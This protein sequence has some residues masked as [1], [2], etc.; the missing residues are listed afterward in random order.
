MTG[1]CPSSVSF[2][3]EN[4]GNACLTVECEQAVLELKSSIDTFVDPCKDFYGFSCGQ[5]GRANGHVSYMEA[6]HIAYVD[7]VNAALWDTGGLGA[8]APDSS[9]L[10]LSVV[11]RSCIKFF[12]RAAADIVEIWSASGIDAHVWTAVASFDSLFTLAVGNVLQY[13][14]ESVVDV[15]W[16]DDDNVSSLAGAYIA[17]GTAIARHLEPHSRKLL[18][19]RAILTLGDIVTRDRVPHIEHIDE[20]VAQRT[21]QLRSASET[22]VVA[23]RDL[24]TPKTN[25]SRVLADY[26]NMAGRSEPSSAIVQD[27]AG[28]RGVLEELANADLRAV[29]VYLTLVPLAKF[30]VFESEGQRRVVSG[31]DDQERR[32]KREACVR[33]LELLFGD[34]YGSWLSATVLRPGVADDVAQIVKDVV[35]VAK[36]TNKVFWR[37]PLKHE[38]VVAP[39]CFRSMIRRSEGGLPEPP[40]QDA[41]VPPKLRTDFVSNT[42]LFS[43]QRSRNGETCEP[44]ISLAATAMRWDDA[45]APLRLLVPDFYHAGSTEA[46]VNYGTLAYH[47]AAISFR[48]ALSKNWTSSSDYAPCIA[49]YVLTRLRMF[50]PGLSWDHVIGRHWALQVALWAAA[51]RDSEFNSS[52]DLSRLFFLRFGHTCCS[53]AAVPLQ[54]REYDDVSETVKSRASCNAV[55][56]PAPAFAYAFSCAGMSRMEC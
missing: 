2:W 40:V 48:T 44:L 31:A 49:H 20:I 38:L 19:V 47:L 50:P 11:Y 25:W 18:V 37:I 41:S 36:D 14:M 28:V 1:L 34:G 15:R 21:S 3:V 5:W 29:S 23:L 35:A 32:T 42:I 43:R 53:Q 27:Q 13:A 17:A 8:A 6:Q 9:T 33:V 10:P 46:A 45:E 52:V 12:D 51:N 30:L 7:A 56:M 39:A 24:D 16:R 22:T 54:P 26:A 55:A 4:L